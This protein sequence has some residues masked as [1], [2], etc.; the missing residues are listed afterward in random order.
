MGAL[1]LADLPRDK[2]RFDSKCNELLSIAERIK[3]L[4]DSSRRGSEP[5]T[6][7]RDTHSSTT[8]SGAPPRLRE[9]V[10]TR[11][12][13]NREQIV[14]LENSKL[15]GFV[16]PPWSA[17]SEPEQFDQREDCELFTYVSP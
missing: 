3:Q 14:L 11:S 6:T 12:L 16:F 9:P 13:S 2:R 1:K 10:A 7:N 8:T 5:D 17:L 15:N 4:K